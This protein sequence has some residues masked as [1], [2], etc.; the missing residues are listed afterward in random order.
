[1][2]IL[3]VNKYYHPAGGPE[4]VML[5]TSQHLQSAGH[6]V[7]PFSMRHRRNLKSEY[8]RY[9]VSQVDYDHHSRLPWNLAKTSFRIIFN[10]ETK[11]EME[12]LI[13]QVRPDVAHLHNIYHQLSPSLLLPLKKHKI[14]VVMTIHDFKLLCANY[15]FMRQERPCEECR[16]R[17]FYKAIR[18][19][20]VKESYLK[21]AVSALEMY[22]HS[23]SRVYLR[24]VDRFIALS[25]FTLQK[26]T[27]YG[28]PRERIAYLPNCVDLPANEIPSTEEK[29]ILF[30]GQLSNKN[31]ILELVKVMRG[32]PA[33]K[34][35][36][37]GKGEQE[38]LVRDFIRVNKMANVELMGFL[39]G[40]ELREAIAGCTFLVFPN[41]C[42]HNCPM[43]ILEAFAFGKPV[44]GANLGS[45]PELV[46]DRV[47]GLLFEP[48]NEEDL[49][50]K[51][52]VLYQDPEMVKEM[53]RNAR[54]R[55]EQD[56]SAGGYYP[57]LMRIYEEL[58]QNGTVAEARSGVSCN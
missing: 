5:R 24:T 26:L 13:Q 2:K 52:G 50:K 42:Y 15:T 38:R 48:G 8:G 34:L 41:N 16:G 7:I 45:V 54:R 9:F 22:V 47:T 27:Q 19:R 32:L 57:K 1:M 33:V 4:E 30:V 55:V 44:I 14:P 58:V 51:I 18:Y 6:V 39:G 35:K 21:S 23:L 11:R 28:I 25:H 12:R 46:E 53:G 29:H 10:P 37:V 56:H 43:S 36:V 20:C 31:G 40:E 49:A 17:R 3:M